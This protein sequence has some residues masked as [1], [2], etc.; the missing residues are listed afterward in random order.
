MAENKTQPTD[1]SVEAFLDAVPDEKRRADA[2][3]VLAMMKEATGLEPRMWGP[4]IIGFG[5]SHYKYASGR[6]GD[7]P[8]IGFSPR[9]QNLALYITENFEN[10]LLERLG[11]FSHGKSCLY[12][13]RL[14]QVDQDVLRQLIRQSVEHA[15][16]AA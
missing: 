11:A 13:K 1:A 14:E 2:R 3:V 10:P 4:A 5:Q 16:G 12:I 6:E 15:G 8:L 9:K 7:Q